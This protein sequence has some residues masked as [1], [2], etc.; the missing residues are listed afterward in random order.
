VSSSALPKPELSTRDLLAGWR[1]VLSGR[2]PMLSIEITRECPLRCPGCYAY[3]ETHLGGEVTLRQL[4]DFR[5]DALVEG[6]L[7]LVRKHRPVHVSLVG[8]EPLIRNRELSRILPALGRLGIRTLLVTSGIIPFPKAWMDIPHLRVAVSVD[9]LPEHHDI[10]RKPAT[11]ERILSNIRDC[12]V[13][14]HWVVT[15]PMLQR[16]GY[17][18]EYLSFWSARPEVNRIWASIY[19]P[20]VG[21]H[22]A[23]MLTPEDRR[24]LVGQLANLGRRYPKFLAHP[25]IVAA[26]LEPP[27]NPQECLFSKVS[28]NYSADLKTRVEPCVLGGTPDCSQCGC[29]ASVGL[30]AVNSAKVIGP[31][32][33]AHVLAASMA[34]GRWVA[35]LRHQPNSPERWQAHHTQSAGSSAW[36]QFSH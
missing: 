23:E 8:G 3:G 22:S 12:T 24:G 26:F 20:Q 16:P 19:S 18:D 34:V 9:G 1:E 4:S 36:V 25:H 28:T 27:S 7:G 29:I 2:A 35:G 10:R 14:I 31:W 13:S 11:Y 6:V 17:L 30:H 32:K 5:G 33:V 15:R 21:E